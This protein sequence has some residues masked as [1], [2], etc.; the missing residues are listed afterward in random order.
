MH[1]PTAG[2]GEAIT[3]DAFLVY[4]LTWAGVQALFGAVFGLLLGLIWGYQ[5][6]NNSPQ[7]T[8][9]L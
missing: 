5:K 9:K 4:E 1:L 6:K 3:P 7:I 8:A 2:P